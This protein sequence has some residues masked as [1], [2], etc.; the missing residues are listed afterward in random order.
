MPKNTKINRLRIVLPHGLPP[1]C[2]LKRWAKVLVLVLVSISSAVAYAEAGKMYHTGLVATKGYF[3]V[4]PDGRYLIFNTN[5][6]AHGLRLLDL[7]NGKIT[8]LP[9]E[10]GRNYGFPSW[11]PDGRQVAVVSAIVRDNRYI[12]ED[13]QITLLDA[14]TWK[15]RTIAADEG[16]KFFPFFSEDGKTLYYF[17]GKKRESGKTIA[18]RYD[19]FAIDLASGHEKK[20]T[21]EEFYQ[22]GKGDDDGKT[23]LFQALPNYQRKIKDALD[24]ESTSALFLYNKL[25]GSVSPIW[26]DQSSGIFELTRPLRDK[27]GNLFFVAAKVRPGSGRFLWFLM[28]STGNGNN[29]LVLTELPIG[30]GFDIV[31]NTGEIY[32]MDK[33]GEELI[34]RKLATPA[35]H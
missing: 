27:A 17:K 29:P 5:L 32:V 30:L 16:V 20:L 12:Y 33:D 19:L 34:I 4:S 31:K 1:M 25:T 24:R 28:S 9:T 14:T 7:G 22:A 18:S 10:T 6:L 23:V 26:I 35:A 11:S 21:D 3:S 13:M 2:A 8:I 15:Q